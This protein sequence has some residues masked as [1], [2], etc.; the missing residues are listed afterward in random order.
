MLN[1]LLLF[2]AF[3]NS[4]MPRY[5]NEEQGKQKF[6]FTTFARQ[7]CPSKSGLMTDT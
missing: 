7:I 2:Q 3:R 1:K 5:T 4:S 6:N